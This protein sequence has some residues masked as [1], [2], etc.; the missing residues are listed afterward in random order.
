[1]N[2]WDTAEL[3]KVAP[4]AASTTSPTEDDVWL[5][6]LDMV[7]SNTG[8]VLDYQYVPVNSIGA[9]TCRFDTGNVLYSKLRPYLNKVV[10]PDRDG[11]ATSEMLPLR[12]D[13]S[14][15]TR[16]YLTYFLRSPQFVGYIS[17]KVSG[18]KM[19]RANT[20][21][22]RRARIP[23]PSL[24][25][26][27]RIVSELDLI[28]HAMDVKKEQIA[29]LC[30]LVKARFVE[31]F[32]DQYTNERKWP[33]VC[34]GSLFSIGSSK[35]IYQ[36]EQ[37]PDGIP[38]LRISD[39]TER[40]ATGANIAELFI[41]VEKYE[42]LKVAGFVPKSGDIL[43]TSRGTLGQC[44]VI[45]ESDKFYFQDGMI[46]WLSDMDERITIPYTIQL[47]QTPGFRK[48]IDDAPA[49]STVNYLSIARLKKLKVMLPDIELQ[50]QF[51][52]LIDQIDESK[53]A[54]K[55]VLG[56]LQLLYDERMSQYF[57]DFDA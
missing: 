44:Y 43:V 10:L 6:N 48:Q 3:G 52:V 38:F 31:M 17:A 4:I 27:R 41:P 55:R 12:P 34:L 45:T 1:M 11:Y 9:S 19:P 5:L 56:H 47:F 26:Q 49:G 32:G 23:L 13:P 33:A 40:I 25:E 51:A 22:L 53:L 2:G 42:I 24:D 7:E 18:A 57:G 21:A 30:L 14:R 29:Q 36:N 28:S 37:V 39:L 15:L 54:L 16:E 8:V 20:D 50:Q 46:S 35:R